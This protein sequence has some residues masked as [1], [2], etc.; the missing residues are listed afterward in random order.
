MTMPILIAN[1]QKMV[2]KTQFKKTYSILFNAFRKA[3]VDLGYTP[4]CY[5]WD[6]TNP[7]G[8]GYYT[9]VQ[10]NESGD[11]TKYETKDGKFFLPSDLHGHFEDCTIFKNAIV[12]NL[13]I[14]K[15]CNGNAYPACIPEY[16]GNDTLKKLENEDMSDYDI[17]VATSGCAGW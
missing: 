2:L 12:K 13:N 11:C 6:T 17:G 10:R 4:Q 14:I 8:S 9:C 16:K 7:Y 1:Y 3:E 15:K 5:Y